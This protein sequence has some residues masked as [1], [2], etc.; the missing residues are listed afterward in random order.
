M[1]TVFAVVCGSQALVIT[2]LAFCLSR[3][4][5]NREDRT[6]NMARQQCE[7]YRTA[8]LEGRDDTNE[9]RKGQ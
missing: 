7:A 8:F 4:I 2:A 5:E 3:M 6:Q 1:V 9:R